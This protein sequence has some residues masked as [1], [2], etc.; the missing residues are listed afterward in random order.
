[1]YMPRWSFNPADIGSVPSATEH[2]SQ[3][4]LSVLSTPWRNTVFMLAHHPKTDLRACARVKPL[5]AVLG[6]A[7]LST[8]GLLSFSAT[9]PNT[10]TFDISLAGSGSAPANT[11]FTQPV[12]GRMKLGNTITVTT[13]PSAPEVSMAAPVIKAGH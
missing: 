7:A 9:P 10:P 1:M 8:L 4:R 12:V 11:T 3:I 5:G 2:K 13:P 6:G